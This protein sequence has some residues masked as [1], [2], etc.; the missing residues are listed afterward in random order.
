M[1]AVSICHPSAP[2]GLCLRV[3]EELQ[4]TTGAT[5]DPLLR[6]PYSLD[7]LELTAILLPQPLDAKMLEP[8]VTFY[9][10][11]IL[12]VWLCQDGGSQDWKL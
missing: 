2:I 1:T 8:F 10:L 3:S 11:A 5:S 9:P 12:Q 4:F 6:I 7:S